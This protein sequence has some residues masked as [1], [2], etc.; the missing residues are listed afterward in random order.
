MNEL[1]GLSFSVR[2]GVVCILGCALGAVVNWAV[3]ALAWNRRAISPWSAPPDG[4]PQRA[5][6]DRIPVLGWWSLRRESDHHGRGF[7]V[8]PL[9]IELALGVGLGVLYWWEVLCH[10]L[11]VGALSPILGNPRAAAAIALPAATLHAQFFAHAVL[12]TFMAAASLIDIDEKLIP[13]GVTVVGTLAG[14]ILAVCTPTMLLPQARA[15]PPPAADVL[16]T[17]LDAPAG[18]P[19]VVRGDRVVVQSVTLAAPTRWPASLRGAPHWRS[20]AIGI[21]CYWLW[22]FAL[23][24]RTWRGRRGLWFGIRLIALRLVRDIRRPPMLLMLPV[25]SLAIASV[26]WLGG[27]RW[28]GMLSS[29]VGLV[30]AGAVVWGVR[31]VGSAALKREA[32]GFGDV[33]LMMM[34]GTFLGWQACLVLFFLAPFAGLV[35]GITQW[36]VHSDDVIPYGPF[37]CIAAGVVLVA[38]AS[39]WNRVQSAFAFGWLVPIAFVVCLVLMGVMLAVWQM[40][41]E[42][43]FGARTD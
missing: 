29:L 18:G 34:I 12:L 15:L 8:R 38:W 10:G 5:W 7:W 1:F 20:L 32:M 16:T 23:I 30:G 36:V 41:K 28:A 37:L 26:W 43:I 27:D 22:C 17:P 6:H 35:I 3:Y 19:L 39:I 4:V 13:D 11:Y 21:G 33:T 31:I 9:A 2:V 42:A 25:G 24:E 14:L 40:I